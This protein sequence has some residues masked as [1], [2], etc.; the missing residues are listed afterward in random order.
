MTGLERAL[1]DI[2]EVRERLGNVQRFKGYSALA[3]AASGVFALTA[4]A[5]QLAIDPRVDT[6]QRGH[7][8]FA[9]WLVCCAASVLINY[10][11]IAHWYVNDATARERW[12]TATVGLSIAPAL[13]LGAALS[14]A[15]LQAGLF[16]FLPGVWCGCY[17]V[18]L[19]ASRT[20]IP[21]DAVFVA[22]GFLIAGCVLLFTP[23]IALQWWVLAAAFGAG[24]TAIAVFV[25]RERAVHA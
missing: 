3:S 5:V 25:A 17:G 1:A 23:A 7:L 9:I 2:A 18:G 19:F 11:A 22:A 6:V 10:G 24:Q 20:T 21:R 4:G 12:Q 16:A 13:V 14:L 8:Y 15:L